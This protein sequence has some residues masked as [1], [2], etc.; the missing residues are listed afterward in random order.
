MNHKMLVI[1]ALLCG[2]AVAL[3]FDMSVLGLT[4][5]DLE[6]RAR[7]GLQDETPTFPT[8]QL[9]GKARDAARGMSEQDRVAAVRAVGAAMKAIV[10]SEAFQKAHNEQIKLA[11]KAVDHGIKVKSQEDVLAAMMKPVPGQDP[12]KDMQMQLLAQMTMEL[13][14]NPVSTLKMMFDDDLKSWTRQAKTA[15]SPKVKAKSQKLMTRATEIQPWIESKP[16]DFKKAYTLLR[17]ID[18]DGPET[19]EALI[20]LANR[21]Q[22]ESE[23][24]EYDK[25]NWKGLL[26]KKLNNLVSEAATVDFA[27]QTVAAGS[28]KKFVNPAYEKKSDLWKAMF[29]AGKAPTLAA[30][31]MAKVWLKEL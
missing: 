27:A 25:Y 30:S 23:Q 29:R 2:S 6:T 1:T 15:S 17:C 10:T 3:Q 20:A 31:D 5:K 13:R 28:R 16:E 22:I 21:G 26:K 7:Y 19:E 12:M 14:K 8:P 11:H 18:N 24:R 4:Q 9:S